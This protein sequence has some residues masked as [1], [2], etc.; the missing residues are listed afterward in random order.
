M[1]ALL[2]SVMYLVVRCMDLGHCSKSSSE[3]SDVTANFAAFEG[4][5]KL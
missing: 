4:G 5:R 3:D 1:V 2:L